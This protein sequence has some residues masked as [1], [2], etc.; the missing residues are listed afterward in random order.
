MGPLSSRTT[1][2]TEITTNSVLVYW[3]RTLHEYSP[4]MTDVEH[5]EQTVDYF[6]NLDPQSPIVW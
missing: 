2:S 3:N 1:S 5:T 6:E 4:S